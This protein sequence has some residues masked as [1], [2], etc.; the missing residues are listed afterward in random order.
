MGN[1]VRDPTGREQPSFPPFPPTSGELVAWCARQWGDAD[2]VVLGDHRL[3][4]SAAEAR[5]AALAKGLLAAGVG[6]G[7][8]VGLLAPNGPEWVVAWLAA[9]RIGA[10]VALLNTYSKARELGRA[11]RHAD[12]AHLITVPSYL[13]NDY[14]E[15]LMVAVPGIDEQPAEQVLLASHPF[16]RAV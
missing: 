13:G 14:L 10:V 7:S 4:Y 8:R 16:L 2:L 6:K 15:R 1:E 11:L 5:S 3:T 9:T 12:V